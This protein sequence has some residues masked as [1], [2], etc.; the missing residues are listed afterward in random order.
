MKIIS[1][2]AENVK[3]LVAVEI[4]PDGNM[5]IIA[6]KNAAGKTSVLDSIW[7][8]LAGAT[9]I[10]AA[11]IRKGS[12]EARIK[13][14]LG[15]LRVTRT[16][17]RG[18]DGAGPTTSITVENAEGARFPSPQRMLD[19]LIGALSFDPL[20]F[21]RMP[22]AEQFD[23]LRR[24]VPEV[25]F[26]A[27]E[28]ADRGD[29][30]R[31]TELG[32]LARQERAAAQ[33][34][35]TPAETPE[36]EIDEAAL[37]AD[38]EAAG[39]ANAELEARKARRERAEAD[40]TSQRQS[41]QRWR[42]EA[43]KLRKQAEETEARAAEMDKAA[44]ELQDKL[45]AAAPL[46]VPTDTAAIRERIAAA[47]KVNTQVRALSERMKHHTR[48]LGLEQQVEALTGSI[49]Q[50]QAAKD[51]AIAAAAM[52]VPGLGFGDRAVLMDGLPF[53][54]ASDAEQLRVSVA[55]AIALNPKLRVIR[56]RDGSL[57]DENSLTLLARMADENEMQVWLEKVDSSGKVGFVI[58]DGR[59]IHKP[60]DA[61]PAEA[62]V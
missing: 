19:S 45:T 35:N 9:H 8:C 18:N 54:Q 39:A 55:I 12:A 51:A 60:G 20:E 13:L 30:E 22:P 57:L 62:R 11:P 28:N 25:D 43:E 49:A 15:E 17:K 48:A 24:F 46:A 37:V 34:I 59:V 56:V 14:D 2:I 7:W 6:G 33:A 5:V 52:P 41:A 21:A 31:R 50:R 47:R 10:Q 26:V 61:A 3:K 32:R 1:L 44:A 23:A 53:E 58:E 29:R 16:F 36:V 4:R 27:I 38:L 40:V 42:D